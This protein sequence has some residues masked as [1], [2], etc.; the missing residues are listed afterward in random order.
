MR[1]P[2]QP[3]QEASMSKPEQPV[4]PVSGRWFNAPRGSCEHDRV[5]MLT[6]ASGQ[7]V[8]REGRTM[9]WCAQCEEN[10]WEDLS[11]VSV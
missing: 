7:Q 6:D 3:S 4:E 9:L 2:W 11:N 10:W 5:V 1:S 8:S